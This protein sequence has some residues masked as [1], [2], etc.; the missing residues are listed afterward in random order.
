VLIAPNGYDGSQDDDKHKCDDA[1]PGISN[2]TL[3]K[4]SGMNYTITVT[5][6]QGTN[7]LQQLD[8]KVNGT[9]VNSIPVS[10]AGDYSTNFTMTSG[11]QA[12]SATVTDTALYT[13]DA[14]QNFTIGGP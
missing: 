9:T 11:T 13:A 8:F 7:S 12:V 14:T 3:K 1:K 6:S 2:I 10:S 4:V 5:V